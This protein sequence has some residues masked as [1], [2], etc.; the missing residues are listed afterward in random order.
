MHKWVAQVR[1]IDY[2]SDM[3]AM[4]RAG[5]CLAFVLAYFVQAAAQT[6]EAAAY[7]PLPVDSLG[8][9]D[10]TS[11]QIDELIRN[12]ARARRLRMR[13]RERAESA[14]APRHRLPLNYGI[15]PLINDGDYIPG[16]A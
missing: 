11:E 16:G 15:A 12:R 9:I 6:I 4:R 10:L 8:L 5:L 7:R 14:T 1:I 3:K 2:L 13:K